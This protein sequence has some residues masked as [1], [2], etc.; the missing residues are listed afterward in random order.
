M[1]AAGFVGLLIL[2][3]DSGAA[4]KSLTPSRPHPS[5]ALVRQTA[6]ADGKML[7]PAHVRLLH[8]S[9]S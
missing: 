3:L 2:G 9:T 1:A 7:T 6:E 4:A 5:A 8:P